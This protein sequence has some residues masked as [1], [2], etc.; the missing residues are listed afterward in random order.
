MKYAYWLDWR[1]N[2]ESYM[3]RC[4]TCCRAWRGP[5]FRQEAL[6]YAPGF[7][8]MQKFYVDLTGSHVRSKGYLL[9][10]IRCFTKYLIAVPLRDKNAPSGSR[11]L[12][13]YVYCLYGSPEIVVSV[14]GGKFLKEILS[15]VHQLMRIKTRPP[16]V[17]DYCWPVETL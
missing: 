16:L 1:E 2:V 4:D 3:R 9:S 5:R 12:V 15:N 14:R 10:G 17:I 13:K 8:A 7:T 11:A 6:Q